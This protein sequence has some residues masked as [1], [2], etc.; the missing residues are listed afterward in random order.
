MDKNIIV[1]RFIQPLEKREGHFVGIEI[2]L[3]IV[4]LKKAPVSF[5]LVHK[6][7]E[8]FV[9]TQ[10]FSEITRDE[11]GWINHACHPE[12]GDTLS[13]ECSYN[14]IEFSFAREQDIH[15]VEK[16]F[17]AYVD[18]VQ[19]YLL[20][21]QHTLTGMGINPGYH[22]NE[23][24]PVA[25]GRYRMLYHFLQSYKEYDKRMP[26]HE[27]PNFGMFSAASQVQLDVSRENVLEAIN[28]FNR[29]EPLKALLFANSVWDHNPDILI[30]RDWLWVNSLQGLNPHN[31]GILRNELNTID[32][33][34]DY[35][36]S[37][38]MY[39]VERDGHYLYFTPMK[40]EEYFDAD[41]VTGT[42][43]TPEGKQQLTFKPKESDIVYLRSFK[44]VDLTFRGTLELRSVCTQPIA[45]SFASAAFHAGLMEMLPELTE[46][47][48]EADLYRQGL[49]PYVLRELLGRQSVPAFLNKRELSELLIAVLDLARKGLY[50]RG[51]HEEHFLDILYHRAQSLTNPAKEMTGKDPYDFIADYAKAD[52]L[53]PEGIRL[54]LYYNSGIGLEE[55][56]LRVRLDGYVADTPHPFPGRDAIDRDF[57]EAQVEIVTPVRNTPESLYETIKRYRSEVVET[58]WREDDRCELL[59]PFS[60][61]PYLTK[62]EEIPIAQFYGEDRWKTRYRTYLA[63]KYGRQKMLLSGIHFN[64]SYPDYYLQTA[65]DQDSEADYNRFVNRRYLE[66]A[67]KTACYSWLIVALTAASPVQDGS[68]WDADGIGKP[69]RPGYGSLR[70]SEH[71]YWN[72][73]IPVFDYRSIEHYVASVN[74]YVESG[75]LKEERELYYPIRLKSPGRFRMSE[76]AVHGVSHIEL[77]MLDLNPLFEAGI[78]PEDLRFLM[79]FL[80]WLEWKPA[81]HADDEMQEEFVRN[82]IRASHMPLENERITDLD[83]QQVPLV[84]AAERI[85]DDMERYLGPDRT[86]DLQREKLRDPQKRYAERLKAGFEADFVQKGL[87][88]TK[89]QTMNQ[90]LIAELMSGFG[91]NI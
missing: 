74:R 33:L 50:Q 86:I 5:D 70:C 66:L 76:L 61:P 51:F 46:L 23:N 25:N 24:K 87:T 39:C 75:Q 11:D 83:G 31:V 64:F 88:Y 78:A 81:I 89:E 8:D 18:A 2:E 59:W 71:G 79:L 10:G 9:Q 53:I 57:C 15:I 1:R 34:V 69:G 35:I 12:T 14:T 6:M 26:F 40:A 45:D 20:P 63:D 43:H 55:E 77:R 4:N 28:T 19:A 41:E 60:N 82:M 58:I 32:D 56:C 80:I 67:E 13:Y 72:D 49:T 3:P 91:M 36:A 22:F 65:Y 44:Y 21:A 42:Y 73:F 68:F 62:E 37:M 90:M 84:E 85:L 27:F 16:R 7:T 17:R 48:S 30:N 47:L 38:S 29:L 52:R 54:D